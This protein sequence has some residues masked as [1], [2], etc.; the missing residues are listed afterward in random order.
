MLAVRNLIWYLKDLKDR[1]ESWGAISLVICKFAFFSKK[2]KW[3]LCKKSNKIWMYLFRKH[4][5][6]V[7][8]SASTQGSKGIRQWPIN[9]WHF[10]DDTL[11]YHFTLLQLVVETF[12]HST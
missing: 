2:G 6:S 10:N 5:K 8:I 3:N 11:N 9:W 1:N 7:F 4:F 12:G